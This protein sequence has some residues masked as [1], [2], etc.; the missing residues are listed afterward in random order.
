[1]KRLYLVTLLITIS[2]ILFSQNSSYYWYKGKKV[3]L[4]SLDT[5]KFL[6]FESESEDSLNVISLFSENDIKVRNM[7]PK[8]VG[9]TKSMK[10]IIAGLPRMESEF[11]YAIRVFW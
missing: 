11:E 3:T 4:E 5:K 10:W 1:M 9:G 8:D 6:I 7:N 2:A